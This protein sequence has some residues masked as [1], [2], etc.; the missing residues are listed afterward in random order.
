MDWHLACHAIF[1][2][3]LNT[4]HRSGLLWRKLRSQMV[5]R[6]LVG[7]VS[8]V[9]DMCSLLCTK[10]RAFAG[11]TN[12]SYCMEMT[13][14]TRA[15]LSQLSWLKKSEQKASL[16]SSLGKAGAFARALLSILQVT[17]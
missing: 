9:K 14:W 8:A 13:R 12:L 4:L 11:G 16:F 2:L 10:H 1:C 6:L 3:T 15:T 7:K 17:H 5:Q